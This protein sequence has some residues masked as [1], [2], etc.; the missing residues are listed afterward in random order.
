MI[1]LAAEGLLGVHALV[2]AA[3]VLHARALVHAAV[4][5]L[6]GVVTAER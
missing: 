5:R 4:K 3:V 1:A 6:V 2:R